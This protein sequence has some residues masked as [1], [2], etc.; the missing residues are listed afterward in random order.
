MK[1][2]EN[3]ELK[4]NDEIER[5]LRRRQEEDCNDS[6]VFR[7]EK[8]KRKVEK[9]M[10]DIN[11]RITEE[12]IRNVKTDVTPNMSVNPCDE[13]E[14]IP[15]SNAES[16]KRSRIDDQNDPGIQTSWNILDE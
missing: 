3:S 11:D 8:T 5:E 6:L 13:E 16:G 12:D 4:S 14:N 2:P 1:T 7:D 10:S 15:S 9:H